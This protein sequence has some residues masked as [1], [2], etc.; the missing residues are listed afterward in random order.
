MMVKMKVTGEVHVNL[1][2]E[3]LG[4]GFPVGLAEG[5]LVGLAEGFAEN[6]IKIKAT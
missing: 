4:E 3:G 2:E 1:N 6:Q 5:S